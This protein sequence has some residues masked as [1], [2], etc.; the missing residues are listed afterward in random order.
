MLLNTIEEE[1]VEIFNTFDLTERERQNFTKVKIDFVEYCIP[2]KN[3]VY[4][5]Y[6][7]KEVRMKMNPSISS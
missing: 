3:I 5:I 6:F 1:A 7:T 2:K 4:H